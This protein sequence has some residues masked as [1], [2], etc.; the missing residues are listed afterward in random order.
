MPIATSWERMFSVAR[1]WP[2]VAAGEE[3]AGVAGGV[4]ALAAVLEVLAQEAIEQ[5]GHLDRDRTEGDVHPLV[6]GDGDLVGA[7]GHDA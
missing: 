3:P 5:W 6:V 2:G 4:E 1:W 7:H